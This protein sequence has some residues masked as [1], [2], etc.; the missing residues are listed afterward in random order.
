MQKRTVL[1]ENALVLFNEKNDNDNEYDKRFF[2]QYKLYVE[3]TDRISQR[4][5]IANS[6]FITANAALLTIVSWFK[7]NFGCYI[8]LVSAI[9]VV[10]AL[11]WYFSIRSYGQLNSGRFK[12]IHEIE[13]KLPLNIFSYE[14]ELLGHGK[15]FK[16][17][18]PLSHVE[19]IVPLIFI[20]L[21]IALCLPY[22]LRNFPCEVLVDFQAI[23]SRV[24]L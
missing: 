4:R 17:Y 11:F 18:W 23:T 2:E 22:Y 20:V 8:L 24:L 15:S 7:D 12:L 21:Y 6:F 9:G 19:R 1:Q 5:S 13:C 10:L 3:L 16:T 14:W